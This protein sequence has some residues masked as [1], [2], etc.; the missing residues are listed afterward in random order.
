MKDGL[1]DLY[2]EVLGFNSKKKEE[3]KQIRLVDFPVE[4]LH[5][6][7]E[8]FVVEL[9]GEN[10][11][12]RAGRSPPNRV[13]HNLYNELDDLKGLC[14]G[15]YEASYSVDPKIMSPLHVAAG[16]WNDYLAARP[17][18]VRVN[19]P[20]ETPKTVGELMAKYGT[21]INLE[22]LNADLVKVGEF[23]CVRY[24]DNAPILVD[25]AMRIC[26]FVI[27]AFGSSPP[28]EIEDYLSTDDSEG[29]QESTKAVDGE[30]SKSSNET[31]TSSPKR[32]K[33]QV[34]CVDLTA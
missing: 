14:G 25:A 8:T 23:T 5:E 12:K 33:V 34:E 9:V 32:A 29:D 27:R 17:K 20:I 18:H 13:T 24:F 21:P 26:E 15:S 30:M 16:H 28:S 1:V 6:M 10:R 7:V 2:K 31:G 19:D 3:A 11:I 22:W 4:A